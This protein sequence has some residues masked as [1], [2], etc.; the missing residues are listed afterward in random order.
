MEEV[1]QVIY[2]EETLPATIPPAEENSKGFIPTSNGLVSWKGKSVLE[3]PDTIKGTSQQS[4]TYCIYKDYE[5]HTS[6]SQRSAEEQHPAST[7]QPSQEPSSFL[8]QLQLMMENQRKVIEF[9][10]ERIV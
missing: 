2:E 9:F 5:P 7:H 3:E 4:T 10:V 6:P 8:A 1:Q